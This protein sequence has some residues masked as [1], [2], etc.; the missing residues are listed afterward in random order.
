MPDVGVPELLII[1]VIALLIF[2]P[3]KMA[4]VG[5]ALGKSIREFRKASKEDEGTSPQVLA[6][7]NGGSAGM[8]TTSAPS[9]TDA[10]SGQTRFCTECGKQNGADQNFCS[11]CGTSMKVASA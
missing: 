3:A 6:S 5:G 4:D 10:A 7:A 2:G 11:Q 1:A 9:A 8:Q